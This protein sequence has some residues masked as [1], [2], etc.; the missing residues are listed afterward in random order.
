MVRT[1]RVVRE[2]GQAGEVRYPHTIT[3]SSVSAERRS[4]PLPYRC[5]DADNT[6]H[7]TPQNSTISW[8]MKLY[9]AMATMALLV[10]AVDAQRGARGGGDNPNTET[11]RE[12]FVSSP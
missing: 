3:T 7:N 8:K 10:M 9:V 12:C 2:S 1:L 5:T 4:P 11:R 6:Q